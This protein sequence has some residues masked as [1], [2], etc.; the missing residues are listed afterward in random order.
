MWG[1]QVRGLI[2]SVPLTVPRGVQVFGQTLFLV[3]SVRV[4]LDEISI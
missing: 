2:V 4:F 1:N 3:G